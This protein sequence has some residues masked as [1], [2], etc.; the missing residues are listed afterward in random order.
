M[1]R[2]RVERR[3]RWLER[4]WPWL[5]VGSFACM[6]ALA[7]GVLVELGLLERVDRELLARNLHGYTFLGLM[8]GIFALLSLSVVLAYSL[9]K[10]WWQEH[11][12][13]VRS[14]MMTWLWSHVTLGVAALALASFHAGYGLVGLR[15][16]TGKVA[17]A[18]LFLIAL[19][20]VVWRIVY[21]V[22]PPI[23]APRIGNYSEEGSQ[24]RADEQLTEIDKLVAGRSQNL[25]ALKDAIVAGRLHAA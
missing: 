17:F 9:R 15:F 22:V 6:T 24:R 18:L 2:A 23:A 4:P 20:G 5:T 14:T 8:S 25:H 7:T 1:K 21:Q 19:S 10:R 11:F 3:L 12:P 16:G 13:L